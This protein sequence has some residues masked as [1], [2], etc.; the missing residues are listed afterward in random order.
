MV[1]KLFSDKLAVLEEQ[2]RFRTLKSFDSQTLLFS[3]NDYLGL[4]LHPKVKAAAIDT[5]NDCGVGARSARLLTSQLKSHDKLESEFANFLGKERALIF[6]TG[7]AANVAIFTSLLNKNDIV[8]ADR[9]IHASIID[10]I[11][12]SKAKLVRFRHNDIASLKKHLFRFKDF[13]G[14]K[15]IATEGLFS[16]DGD[17]ALLS[18]IQQLASESESILFVDEAHSFGIYGPSGRGIADQVGVLDK[19]DIHLVTFAKSLGTAGAVVTGSDELI[20]GLINFARGFIYS[21]A[22]PPPLMSATSASLSIIRSKE[23]DE[24]RKKLFNN[25]KK[26]RDFF[27]SHKIKI[28]SDQTPIIPL[29]ADNSQMLEKLH[30]RLLENKIYVPIIKSPT[31]PKNEER[32]RISVLATHTDSDLELFFNIFESIL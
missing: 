8:F 24:L 4:A 1:A 26:M 17:L 22:T 31:V 23:G 30:R 12:Y 13:S 15:V 19:V 2:N 32:L 18:Q 25:V 9:F 29:L 27:A 28:P 21:S 10:G 14:R 20:D 6:S 7:Y 16:M 3:L 11:R 5:I